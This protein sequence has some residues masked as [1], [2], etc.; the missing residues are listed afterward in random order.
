MKKLYVY[1]CGGF[2]REVYELAERINCNQ[3]V[4]DEISFLD[5]KY[6]KNNINGINVYKYSEI[7][8]NYPTNDYEI[9][10]ATGEPKYREEIYTKLIANGSKLATLIH[11]NVYINKNSIIEEGCIICEG[12]I[13]TTNYHIKKCSIININCTIGHDA[14]I[15]EFC[16]IS[17]SCNVS[18][19]VKINDKAYI[20]SGCNI[21][22]EVTIGSNSIIG[23]GSVVTKDIPDNVI[24]Y[25]SP[26]IIKKQNE[27][28]IVFK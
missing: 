21:R 4:W 1:C 22:D 18:G 12:A 23:I 25:G 16:T 28:K 15:G 11:P 9:I 13:L 26:A 27:S 24:A 6:N 5:D 2:G 8:K 14:N 20:G 10:I 7:I 17:P 3:K 19:S